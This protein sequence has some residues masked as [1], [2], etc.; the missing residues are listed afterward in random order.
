M[1]FRFGDEIPEP[2]RVVPVE[3][4][5]FPFGPN[6]SERDERPGGVAGRS[7]SEPC[8]GDPGWG[9][10]GRVGSGERLNLPVPEGGGAPGN[11]GNLLSGKQ[12]L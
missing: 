10:G 5:K 11:V 4:R 7:R 1:F 12:R 6:R 8:G 9:R 3:F 2:A